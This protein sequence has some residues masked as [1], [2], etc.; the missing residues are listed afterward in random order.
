MVGKITRAQL[1]EIAEKIIE[2]QEASFD[3]DKFVDHYEDALRELVA[4]KR[5]GKK[6]VAA[7]PAEP[8]K[9]IDL[10]AA[11]KRSLGK[12]PSGERARAERFAKAQGTARAP[13]SIKARG[14]AGRPVKKSA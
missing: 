1:I 7:A 6:I 9:V 5:K 8:E 12:P 11:L 10:M 4:A 2:Q 14:K 3:P 13:R